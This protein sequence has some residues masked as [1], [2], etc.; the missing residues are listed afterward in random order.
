MSNQVKKELSII[1]VNWNCGQSIIDCLNSLIKT[2]HQVTY[3]II[4]VD[5]NSNDGSIEK[6]ICNFPSIKVIKNNFNNMFAGANNQGYAV[7][8]GKYVFILNS[9]T[10]ATENAIDSMVNILKKG[11]ESVLTCTLLNIDGSIQYNMHRGFPTFFRLI[12]SQFYKKW[13]FFSFLPSVKNYLLINNKFDKDFYVEQAAGAAILLKR[14][15]I[16]KL[17]YLFDERNF[18]LLYNDVDL[19]YRIYIAGYKILCKTDVKIIHLKG[20]SLKKITPVDHILIHLNSFLNFTK[21]HRLIMDYW[22]TKIVYVTLL[23]I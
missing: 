8:E 18:P 20:Q 2:I 22:L 9:D 23:K 21:K 14:S 16:E 19:S 3:E 15:L 6:I 4:V 7:S 11:K 12:A 10:V 1:L 17:G 5:N 13:K